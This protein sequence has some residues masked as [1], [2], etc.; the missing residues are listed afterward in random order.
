[1]RTRA[2]AS[3]LLL[4]IG[5]MF[6]PLLVATA[7]A[8]TGH[9]QIASPAITAKALEISICGTDEAEDGHQGQVIAA[10]ASLFFPS[11]CSGQNDCCTGSGCGCEMV[12]G[13]GSCGHIGVAFLSSFTARIAPFAKPAIASLSDKLLDD[14]APCPGDRPPRT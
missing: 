8:H 11:L 6:W 4:L 9:S 10:P 2:L 14:D 3:G 1:M 13:S 12:C 7:V 5:A